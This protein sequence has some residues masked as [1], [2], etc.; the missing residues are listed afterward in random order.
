MDYL[1]EQKR[2]WEAERIALLEINQTDRYNNNQIWDKSIDI[3]QKVISYSFIDP[4]DVVIKMRKNIG[5]GISILQSQVIL[6]EILATFQQ[7]KIFDKDN[8][9]GFYYNNSVKPFV[10]F[11]KE[12]NIFN[13]VFQELNLYYYGSIDG[14]HHS[15]IYFEFYF[16]VRCG[17]VHEGTLKNNWFVNTERI[18][19]TDD[20]QFVKIE[21][22]K[23]VIYRNILQRT[24]K[25]YFNN[26]VSELKTAG[27]SRRLRNFCRRLDCHFNITT[28]YHNW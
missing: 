5:E 14:S 24:I 17:L 11:L 15:N 6:I 7:G 1:A 10:K 3:F 22:G 2:N 19:D 27:N 28:D 21:G 20:N 25:D 26:Y 8:P 13:A 9:G 12:N 16:D 4:I 18:T 23:K